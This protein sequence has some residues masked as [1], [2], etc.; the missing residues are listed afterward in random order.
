MHMEDLSRT[1]RE[2]FSLLY[3]EEGPKTSVELVEE[4]ESRGVNVDA[5]T[6][7]YHLTSLEKEGILEKRGRKGAFLTRK[8]VDV[9]RRLLLQERFGS[10]SL[11]VERLLW[12]ATIDPVR[13]SGSA[14]VNMVLL[15]ERHLLQALELLSHLATSSLIVSP[16]LGLLASGAR[17]WHVEV[18]VGSRGLLCLSSRN[19]DVLFRRAGIFCESGAT[20]LFRIREGA[21]E[22]FVELLSASGSTLS[23]GELL[24][25]GRY[26]SVYEAATRGTGYVT[27][28]IKLFPSFLYDQVRRVVA[29][30]EGIGIA[31]IVSMASALPQEFASVFTARNR[32]ICLVYGGANYV[33]PLVEKGLTEEL[34][35][36]SGLYPLENMAP[37]EAFLRR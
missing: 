29:S 19:Y 15:P 35:I 17:L 34:S 1:V 25:R 26:T 32:G 36:A 14:V 20:G 24:I 31:G 9:A 5:R 6:V 2:V 7:R 18:P 13:G 22:G 3:F 30:L 37:P 23:P 16:L 8:G 12:E 27:T 33:A 4:L 28:G 11:E 21:P 10:P